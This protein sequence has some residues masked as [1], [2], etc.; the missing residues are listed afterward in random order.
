MEE[1]IVT[2]ATAKLAE[3]KGFTD[4]IGCFRGKDYYN[5]NG[6]LDGDV[7]LSIRAIVNK[8]PDVVKYKSIAAPTQA[9]LQKWLRDVHEIDIDCHCDYDRKNW[10]FGYRMRGYCYNHYPLEYNSYE[11]ALEQGLHEA[12]KLI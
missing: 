8:S 2:Y 12:L 1:Q 5:Y 6:E 11:E 10:R 9:L 4:V 3:E 7:T